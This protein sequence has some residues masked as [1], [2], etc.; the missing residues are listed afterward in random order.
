MD[1]PALRSYAEPVHRLHGARRPRRELC[2]V[3]QFHG[4]VQPHEPDRREGDTRP[5]VRPEEQLQGVC[6]RVRDVFFCKFDCYLI[7]L[8]TP[9][10]FFSHM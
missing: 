2:Q 10:P 7:G 8:L 1:E 4:Q 6:R 5:H 3:G 9:I